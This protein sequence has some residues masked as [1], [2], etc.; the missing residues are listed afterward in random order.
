MSKLKVIVGLVFIINCSST[1]GQDTISEANLMDYAS[2]FF[3]IKA[4][5][6]KGQYVLK[7]CNGLSGHADTHETT[8]STLEAFCV[9]AIISHYDDEQYN[10]QKEM[11]QAV[12]AICKIK[13]GLNRDE[14]L[15]RAQGA[16]YII[17][18]RN[19]K[20]KEALL[21]EY[22]RQKASCG[23]VLKTGDSS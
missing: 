20:L 3:H 14:Q 23:F 10:L 8:N 17:M 5:N 7:I 9:K 18:A 16:L 12:K 2:K 11:T 15:L 21:F 22:Q 6:E 13:M 4:I 1:F 19:E